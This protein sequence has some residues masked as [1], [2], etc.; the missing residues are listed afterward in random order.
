[1]SDLGKRL[2]AEVSAVTLQKSAKIGL[3]NARANLPY[4]K[5]TINDLLPDASESALVV[6]GGPSLHRQKTAQQI[7]QS[8]YRGALV[9]VDGA[10]GYC[11]RNGVVPRYVISVDP[12][13]DRIVR[14]FGDP[15]L[16]KRQKD[17]YFSRQEMDPQFYENERRYNAELLALVDRHGSQIKAILGTSVSPSVTRRCLQ[18][19]MDVYWWNPL[20]DDYD[21]PDSYSR[22]AYELVGA[23]CMVTGGNVGSSAWVFAQA[24]LKKRYVALVGMDLGYPPDHPVQNTQYYKELSE[25][26]GERANEAFIHVYNP[27]LQ[28]TWYTDPTY[29]WYQ[30]VF[31]EMVK[32]AHGETYNCTEGG[33][34]FGEG[35][36]FVPLAD[37]LSRFDSGARLTEGD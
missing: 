19:G 35:I 31:I 26:F 5:K 22:Q 7:K 17:D 14:W 34:L 18:A 16:D 27:Y 1:M 37:F 12:H 28:Q 21:Q 36:R 10:M 11:L 20:Y 30:Q 3:E 33:I 9:S 2:S 13:P 29:Y 8:G 25:M 4:I 15:D 24:I 6:S 32:H 23:P